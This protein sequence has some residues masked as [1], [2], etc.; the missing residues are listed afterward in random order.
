MT[1]NFDRFAIKA[2]ASAGFCV[3]ALVLSP[4][5]L[6]T[7]FT[8]GGGYV[9]VEAPAGGAGPAAAGAAAPCAAAAV[10]SAGIVPPVPLGPPPIVPP[11]LVPPLVPPPLVP[12]IVPPPLVPPLVPPPVVPPV[13]PP[14]VP[15]V[16]PV[17]AA[18]PALAGAPLMEMSGA[19][20]KGAPTAPAGSNGPPAGVP[21]LPG[22]N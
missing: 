1:V 13:V 10:Q 8:T 19:T 11:P 18:A 21:A 9:C 17:A 20:G 5:A 6:A 22:P 15:P 16:V 4:H 2:I 3:S 7:P 14:I 12:P